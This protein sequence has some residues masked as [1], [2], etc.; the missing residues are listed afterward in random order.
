MAKVPQASL[1]A[2]LHRLRTEN[3]ELKAE[4]VRLLT[5]IDY[6]ETDLRAERVMA[7]AVARRR[8]QEVG[9]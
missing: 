3:S 9:H 2:A 6:L 4:N 7:Q 1:R 5:K 8:A